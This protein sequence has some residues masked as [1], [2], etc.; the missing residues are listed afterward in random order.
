MIEIFSPATNLI[1]TAKYC[2]YKGNEG[3]GDRE[4]MDSGEYS[5]REKDKGTIV[6]TYVH[7]HTCI[8]VYKHT[9][10]VFPESE[11]CDNWS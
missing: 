8:H 7:T 6:S 4:T 3:L 9:P 11:C 1:T 5:Q 10:I 2:S